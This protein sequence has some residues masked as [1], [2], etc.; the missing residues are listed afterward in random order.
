MVIIAMITLQRR[1][2]MLVLSSPS[3]AGKTSVSRRLL[4][5][6]PDLTLSIS[7]TTRMPRFGEKD[8]DHYHFVDH[9]KF[10]E[11]IISGAF[12]EYAQVFGHYYGTPRGPVEGALAV[13][14]DVLFDIDWQ[15]TQQ[16]AQTARHD[17]ASVFILPPS[18]GE[19]E[20]RLRT[21]AQDSE[22]IVQYRMSRAHEEMSHWAEYDYILIN[23]DFD[24][25]IENVRQI[26]HAERLR[27]SRQIGLNEFIKGL[28]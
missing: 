16:L 5:S 1:G 25:T 20:R 23:D 11:Q 13:G 12:L 21:R 22:E 9:D 3:G 10:H 28:G 17:L 6:E 18:W 14:K 4:K 7:W 2:L 27:R 24:Q 8:G 19:L 26:L 15:G